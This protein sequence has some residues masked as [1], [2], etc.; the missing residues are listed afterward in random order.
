MVFP[1][2]SLPVVGD[3]L[4]H[5]RMGF[6]VAFN[7]RLLVLA[8]YSKQGDLNNGTSGI[9]RV[10]R[11]IYADGTRSVCPSTVRISET[12]LVSAMRR[13]YPGNWIDVYVSNNNGQSWQIRIQ[14]T[15]TEVHRLW[16]E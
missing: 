5:Q 16:S 1:V 7:G 12:Q 2:Q 4:M 13:K 6:H 3:V 11:E 9:G 15:I 10:V 8:F 14:E